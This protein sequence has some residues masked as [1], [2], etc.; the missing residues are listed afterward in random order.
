MRAI[1]FSTGSLTLGDFKRAL[2][3]LD[4]SSATAVELSA[5]R[6]H[7][8][9]PMVI[10]MNSLNLSKYSFVSVHAPSN[11]HKDDEDQV[12]HLLLNFKQK[13][14]PIV[15]H[16]DAIYDFSKWRC[17]KNFL[18]LENMDKRKPT[19]RNVF[20]LQEIFDIL[21]DAALCFDLAHAR[22]YD[23]SMTEAYLIAKAFS[24]RISQ[25]HISEVGTQSSHTR[26]SPSAISAY[27][28]I[29]SLIPSNVPIIIESQVPAQAIEEELS[30][31]L[32]ALG[33]G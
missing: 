24:R 5:L 31:A 26:L 13:G 25:V 2:T 11:F 33:N 6:R 28:E 8:L 21:P 14:W 27:R 29:S 4:K 15:V 32:H 30:A 9:D 10:S 12:I 19:G 1:G 7:E 17:F 20:E 23:A 3:W 16:P 18:M 22:Q